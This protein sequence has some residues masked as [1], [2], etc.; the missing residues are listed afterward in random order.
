MSKKILAV[1]SAGGHWQQLQRIRHAFD[2]DEVFFL[3][4]LQG[5]PD[6]FDA[7]PAAIIPDCSQSEP[8]AAL[9][10]FAAVYPIVRRERP[11]VVIT[12][13]ALPGLIAL[14]AGRLVGAKGVWI[15]SVANAECMSTSGRLARYVAHLRLSQWEHVA[16]ESQVEYAGSIL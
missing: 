11:D 13:G 12:T 15:D 16:R 14:A 5:L 10:C 8:L 2:G 7:L 4:T 6:D 1:A 3:T 9:R